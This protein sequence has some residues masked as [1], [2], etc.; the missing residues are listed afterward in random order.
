MGK[1]QIQIKVLKKSTEI[2]DKGESFFGTAIM[3]LCQ[4]ALFAPELYFEY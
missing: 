3:L 1:L 2:N 4:I